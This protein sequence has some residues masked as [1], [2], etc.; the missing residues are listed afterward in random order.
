M[1]HGQIARCGPRASETPVPSEAEADLSA[2]VAVSDLRRRGRLDCSKAMPLV[3][4]AYV[5]RLRHQINFAA[6]AYDSLGGNSRGKHFGFRRLRGKMGTADVASDWL[7]AGEMA[8]HGSRSTHVS[9]A[10]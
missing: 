4:L 7:P 3:R 6:L 8:F 10:G 5:Q 2:A 1:E 9:F